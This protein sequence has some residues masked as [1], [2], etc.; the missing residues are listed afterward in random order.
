MVHYK[1]KTPIE[2]KPDKVCNVAQTVNTYEIPANLQQRVNQ[3][4]FNL[5]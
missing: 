4:M 1:P 5:K 2:K 3:V